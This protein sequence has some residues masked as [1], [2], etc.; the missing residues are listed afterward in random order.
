MSTT[1][2]WVNVMYQGLAVTEINYLPVEKSNPYMAIFFIGFIIV[3]SFFILNLFVGIVIST[4]NREKEKLGNNFLLTDKQKKWLDL[5]LMM[6]KAKPIRR[7]KVEGNSY[8]SIF[9]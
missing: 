9:F 4:F 2:G 1:V 6:F 3:G 8:R 7:V 5:K